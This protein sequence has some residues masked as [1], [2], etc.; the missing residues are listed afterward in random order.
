MYLALRCLV[1]CLCVIIWQNID[2]V[3]RPKTFFNFVWPKANDIIDI[4]QI[5]L[6]PLHML[7]AS[8]YLVF[9]M[10][11]MSIHACKWVCGIPYSVYR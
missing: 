11:N 1:F 7:Y 10:C 8:V 4:L 5:Y 9:Y 2:Q 3:G 6:L